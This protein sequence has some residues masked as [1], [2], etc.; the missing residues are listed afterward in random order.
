MRTIP[1]EKM[2]QLCEAFDGDISV[3]ATVTETGEVFAYN[4]AHQLHAASTIKAPLLA[5][6]LKRAEAGEVDLTKKAQTAPENYN[7]GSGLLQSFDRDLEMS[8]FDKA[9]LMI[10][11]SDNTATNEVIDAVGKDYFNEQMAAL[12]FHETMLGKKLGN[13]PGVYNRTSA[14][15]LGRMMVMA[16]RGELFSAWVSRQFLQI[17]AGQSLRNFAALIPAVD[18]KY[19]HKELPEVPEGCV[20]VASKSGGLRDRG[21]SHDN[22]AFFL[23]DGRTYT[24]AV[25]T[26]SKDVVAA[27]MCQAELARLMYEAM[28][29]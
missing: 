7:G 1:R 15:D 2:T 11:V 25:T 18:F 27:R 12:G 19:P 17:L 16:L 23:P 21:I 20:L 28:K 4:E 3:Y 13:H 9:V 26:Q 22:A 29:E 24:L 5:C 8:L 14:R 6:L 10:V